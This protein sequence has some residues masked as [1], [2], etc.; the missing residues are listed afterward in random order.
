MILLTVSDSS[1]D[2]ITRR[3]DSE[4]TERALG[5]CSKMEA[6]IPTQ[7]HRGC[8]L[9]FNCD[10]QV[11]V[12]RESTIP[13]WVR[14]LLYTEL[15]APSLYFS[16]SMRVSFRSGLLGVY[17][18]KWDC[19][20]I[21]QFYLGH[22]LLRESHE[23]ALVTSYS[24]TNKCLQSRSGCHC[25]FNLGSLSYITYCFH[26]SQHLSMY[27]ILLFIWSQSDMFTESHKWLFWRN[28]RNLHFP[29]ISPMIFA[30]MI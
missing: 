4:P 3:S 18:Q 12:W 30:P 26:F 2:C 10:Q 14:P 9:H 29:Q 5:C 8:Q 22:S 19:W 7:D 27:S 17:A 11:K 15:K 13:F 25:N 16:K 20:I 6:K 21:W 1:R 23:P 24:S 28:W